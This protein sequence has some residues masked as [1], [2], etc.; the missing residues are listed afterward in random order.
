MSLEWEHDAVKMTKKCWFE[1]P[2]GAKQGKSNGINTPLC[3]S[4]G[5]LCTRS[6]SGNEGAQGAY[7]G[8]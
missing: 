6:R 3:R 4:R 7:G 8:R 1:S 5:K 2:K